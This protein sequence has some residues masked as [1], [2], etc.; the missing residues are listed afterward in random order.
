MQNKPARGMVLACFVVVIFF[1][2]A[3]HTGLKFGIV[4]DQF[5]GVTVRTSVINLDFLFSITG[6]P[7]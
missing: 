3:R 4:F 7:E 2:P 6:L 1:I 5:C